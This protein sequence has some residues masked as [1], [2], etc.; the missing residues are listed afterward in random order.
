MLMHAELNNN[1][2]ASAV[3]EAAGKI[4]QITGKGRFKQTCMHST[5]GMAAVSY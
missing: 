5:F 4:Q 1:A 3:T 2:G